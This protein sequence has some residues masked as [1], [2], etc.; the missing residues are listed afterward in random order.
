M[1]IFLRLHNEFLWSDV[2]N[3]NKKGNEKLLCLLSLES[4]P[5]I[6]IKPLIAFPMDIVYQSSLKTCNQ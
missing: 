6:L 1:L 3:N 4:K 2:I 5:C